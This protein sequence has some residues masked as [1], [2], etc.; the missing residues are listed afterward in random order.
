MKK[1]CMA[2]ADRWSQAKIELREILSVPI[3]KTMENS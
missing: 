2:V 1:T 3:Y